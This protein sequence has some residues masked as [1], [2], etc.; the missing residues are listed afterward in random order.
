MQRYILKRYID[1]HVPGDD[2]T[3]AYDAETLT[4][5]VAQGLV[6]VRV[7]SD[8]TALDESEDEHPQTIVPRQ[9]ETKTTPA[10]RSKRK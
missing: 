3:D 1:R 5:W 10:K 2:V 6:T 4:Q 9:P 7:Q 8:S